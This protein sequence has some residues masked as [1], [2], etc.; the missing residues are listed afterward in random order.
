MSERGFSHVATPQDSSNSQCRLDTQKQGKMTAPGTAAWKSD[1]FY[2]DICEAAAPCGGMTL[3][4]NMKPSVND[5]MT[6]TQEGPGPLHHTLAEQTLL[7]EASRGCFSGLWRIFFPGKG[8]IRE[9][10]IKEPDMKQLQ[11][12]LDTAQQIK[13]RAQQ[14]APLKSNTSFI[15]QGVVWTSGRERQFDPANEAIQL[16]NSLTLLWLNF[17]KTNT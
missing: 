4:L 8:G 3:W 7:T 13:S 5:T 12:H 11:L 1:K 14:P 10:K 2:E 9:N 17:Q 6:R 15:N 16:N